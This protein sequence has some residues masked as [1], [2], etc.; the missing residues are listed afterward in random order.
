M[1]RS[2]PTPTSGRSIPAPAAGGGGGGGG[3]PWKDFI[4]LPLDLTTGWTR[5]NGSGA[6]NFT[7]TTST[8]GSGN[9]VTIG[10]HGA[11]A[12]TNV[13]MQNTGATRN[14]M[15]LIRDQPLKPFELAG[16]ELPTG[17]TD[18]WVDPE[19]F[20]IKLQL[21]FDTIPVTGPS[22]VPAGGSNWGNV[23]QVD[24]GL[25][26]YTSDQGGSP[27]MPANGMHNAASMYKG[28]LDPTS[29]GNTFKAGY[30]NFG[31]RGHS[32]IKFK[33]QN[34]FQ[35]TGAD[36]I[37]FTAGCPIPKPKNES[38]TMFGGGYS[39]ID[40]FGPITQYGSSNNSITTWRLNGYRCHPYISIGGYTNGLTRGTVKI[41]SIKMLVQPITGRE[42]F[43]A[44]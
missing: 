5:R 38:Q 21:E 11:D 6:G 9:L 3:N 22:G 31:G 10:A 16:L 12:N 39:T 2:I 44:E 37:V 15:W 7:I 4:E 30:N 29:A 41:R 24:I 19:K 20:L 8:D 28:G 1:A 35:T 36:A 27:A 33:C 18:Y 42:T 43:E 17:Q 14:G 26:Y 34:S 23:I 40:P 25:C 32:W 13:A